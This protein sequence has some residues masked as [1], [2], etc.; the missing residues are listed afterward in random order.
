MPLRNPSS[1]VPEYENVIT[2]AKSGG[3]FT[4]IREALNIAT[5]RTLIRVFP[6]IY[7][8]NN[9]LPS[10]DNVSVVGE[11]G[12]TVTRIEAINANQD[13]FTT[14]DAF[15]LRGLSLSFVSG[16]GWVI[17]VT[18]DHSVLFDN[19]A[20]FQCE[21]G[22]RC[23]N[24]NA[25]IGFISALILSAG[26]VTLS[27][28]IRNNA[29]NVTISGARILENTQAT[30]I[31]NLDGATA[32]TTISDMTS[33]ESGITTM[34]FADNGAR[35][36]VNGC[37]FVFMND[38]F[39][40]QGGSNTQVIA[41]VAFNAGQDAVRIPNVGA[42]TEFTASG[43]TVDGSTR[44]DVNILSAS[45]I[46]TGYGI[47]SLDKMNFTSGARFTANFIDL[48]ED[49]EGTNILGELHVGTPEIG[50]ESVLGGG[51]SYT[52]GMLV[53]TYNPSGAVWTDVST[54]A[55]SASGST[56]TFPAVAQDNAIYVAS[57][58]INGGD[59]LQHFGIKASITTAV[60]LGGGSIVV[61]YWTGAAW[62]AIEHMSTLSSSPY[63][64]YANTIFERTG[65][66]QIRYPNA[67]LSSWTKNDPGMGL[68][69]NYF[70]IRFRV[71]S[72]V[73]TV[74][75]F[76]QFKLH[77]NR[78]EINTDGMLEFFGAARPEKEL[79]THIVLATSV[80][81][82]A[83]GNAAVAFTATTTLSLTRNQFNDNQVHS[84]GQEITIPTGLD[85]SIP[86]TIEDVWYPDTNNAGDVELRA[87]PGQ[88]EVGDLFDGSVAD[89]ATLTDINTVA[90]NSRYQSRKTTFDIDVSDLVPGDLLI[91]RLERD[92]TAGNDPP[93]TLSGNI[94]S[95]SFRAFGV[96]W[97]A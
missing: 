26:A 4:T 37:S 73:T 91:V 90:A 41:S 22:I 28:F 13:L 20:F 88:L 7:Q 74:P 66:E 83:P 23:N 89:G 18:Q 42:N 49:D 38:C 50:S 31:F 85:T 6:G 43:L 17:D 79:I 62:V 3:D 15:V 59:F 68:G 77:T 94:I 24:A 11:G 45:A 55:R 58:L 48:K 82:S 14:A 9:P 67:F 57:S 30:T 54:A 29:G 36:V 92:A 10:L 81:G 53:Y 44:F 12:S 52:R 1:G 71:A 95:A 69:T 63:T 76:Q 40:V 56:F 87:I 96:A 97:R 19:C 39:V 86:I 35:S 27:E 72:A 2:V 34:F 5:A 16:T 60:V 21:Q 64:Q 46:V 65:S 93:D 32:V 51:D 80:V 25:D 47:A 78:T 8:E 84:F 70:W 33:F 75:I 61:E